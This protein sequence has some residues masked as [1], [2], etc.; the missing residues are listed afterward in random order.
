MKF[1]VSRSITIAA[2]LDKVKSLVL[3]FAHWSAWSP[4]TILEPDCKIDITGD[5]GTVDHSMTWEGSMIGSGRNTITDLD[6]HQITYNLQFLKPFK[7]QAIVRFDFAT[8]GKDTSVNWTMDSSMPFF[9][10][11]L[12]PSMKGMLS[13]D[14]DRGLR[15]LKAM[16]ETG[17]V[18]ATT[19]NKG[20]VDLEGF[21]YVGL[22]R[23]V[24]MDQTA[25]TMQTDFDRL[26]QDI[27]VTHKK[28]AQHWITL[29]TKMDMKTM[30]MTYIAAVSDEEL[31][32]VT[33]SD[34]YVRGSVQTSKALEIHHS[35]P[36]DFIGNAWSMGMM[37]LR[38]N[39]LKQA[40]HPFEHY[41]NSPK[42][43]KPED[44]ETSVYFPLK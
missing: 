20:I 12:I 36:Y 30:N 38:A 10:F 16:A 35:G 32:D 6:D 42:E 27:V 21:S 28:S 13:L 44:L 23:T 43:T 29:Y 4:W 37:Y 5:P 17:H 1:Q 18:N 26:I 8:S 24:H 22:L 3:D 9:L 39:K 40:P 11:F 15:M 34:D 2:P 14:F 33:L 31:S 7:S 19:T 25:E 41:W